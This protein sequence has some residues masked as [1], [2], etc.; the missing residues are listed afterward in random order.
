MHFLGA[1]F[2]IFMYS[3]YVIDSSPVSYVSKEKTES[4]ISGNTKIKTSSKIEKYLSPLISEGFH[5]PKQNNYIQ[6]IS[7][8]TVEHISHHKDKKGIIIKHVY[9]ENGKADTIFAVYKN[10][11]IHSF[12]KIR[13]TLT[14]NISLGE[15]SEF[16]VTKD[17][18]LRKSKIGREKIFL[19]SKQVEEFSELNYFLSINPF[20][21]VHKKLTCPYKSAK[22][23]IAI[24][25]SYKIY[26]IE[27]GQIT[28]TLDI[29]LGQSPKGHKVK[30]GDNKTPE[31]EYKLTQ[32]AKGPFSGSVGPYFGERWIRL[33]YPNFYDA[34]MGYKRKL[35]SKSE[36][37]KI[38]TAILNNQ[39]PPKNTNL[40]GGIGIHGWYG[41]WDPKENRD[42]TWGCIS[43]N[44]SDLVPLYD[45]LEVGDNIII[46][47]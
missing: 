15:N 46:S 23:L 16:D 2:L 44:N 36:K 27:K 17:F 6:T 22:L 42:L 28:A 20:V 31:G 26:I 21:K 1:I 5:Y 25:S 9:L 30:Q 19:S 14:G 38:Q 4:L 3:S 40:G 18:E 11:T 10:V 33:S 41:E 8:G 39:M 7:V 24:K 13:D 37:E 34:E 29:A 43:I 35:I 45:K 32:K 47:P 12:I